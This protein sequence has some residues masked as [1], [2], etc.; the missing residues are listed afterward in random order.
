M[1]DPKKLVAETYD[2]AAEAYLLRFGDSA[3][4]ARWGQE[5]IRRLPP[6]GRVLDLGC[7]AGVPLARSLV[8]KG[9]DVLGVDISQRQIELARANVPEARFVQAEMTS[10]EAPDCSFDGVAAFYSLNHLPRDDYPALLAKIRRWLRDGGTFVANF[11]VDNNPAWTGEWL[12][13]QTFFSSFDAP[14]TVQLVEAAG[15][16]VQEAQVEPAD[17][18]DVRFLW[19]VARRS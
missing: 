15:F 9:F 1:D 8:A 19:V 17:D 5:L 2:E 7:G 10:L 18:E 11:G 3:A 14:T 6:D 13:T 12:G 16:D 4:K